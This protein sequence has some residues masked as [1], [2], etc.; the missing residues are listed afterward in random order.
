MYSF[1]AKK[2]A[3]CTILA[4]LSAELHRY[5]SAD[6]WSAKIFRAA[7]NFGVNAV[8]MFIANSR[9]LGRAS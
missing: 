8:L 6:P 1:G 4:A 9:S 3:S 7:K 2:R 5:C